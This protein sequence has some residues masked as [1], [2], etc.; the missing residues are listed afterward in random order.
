MLKEGFLRVSEEFI[1]FLLE[2]FHGF[3]GLGF[4]M[5]AGRKGLGGAVLGSGFRV[6]VACIACKSPALCSTPSVTNIG[7]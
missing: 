2:L 6:S 5:H 1:E 4:G 3:G 7:S